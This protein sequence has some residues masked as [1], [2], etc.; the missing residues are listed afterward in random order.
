MKQGQRPFDYEFEN[1]TFSYM[2]QLFRLAYSRV[3]N[4]QDA[5]DIVQETY[6]KAWRAF[7]SLRR[8][9][10]IKR[11]I[12][13]ILMNTIRDYRRKDTRTVSTVDISDLD[14][15]SFHEPTQI[16]PEEEICRDE[17]DPMLS[18]ALRSIP[19]TFLTPLLL[20]EIHEST[21]DDIAQT[22]D[23]PIGTVMS[24]LFRAARF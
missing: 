13:H 7:S 17:I 12:T 10:S 19:E 2:E 5:E 9:E 4:T 8:R 24:R 22:L 23:I 3:G 16:G 6:L 20:R 14:E 15:S 1:C 21:Y 11:W 18:N